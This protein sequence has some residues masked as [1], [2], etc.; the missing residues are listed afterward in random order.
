MRRLRSCLQSSVD[1]VNSIDI[2]RYLCGYKCFATRLS[3]LEHCY[4]L[5]RLRTV[6]SYWHIFKG[7]FRR[8]NRFN[9]YDCVGILPQCFEWD[10]RSSVT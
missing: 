1:I 8:I 5:V 2:G 6:M 10:H 9:K 4:I 7:Q 3:P